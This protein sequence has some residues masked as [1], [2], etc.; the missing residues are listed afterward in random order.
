M[1]HR[2]LF[3]PIAVITITLFGFLLRLY[4]L[5]WQCL[6]VDEATTAYIASQNVSWIVHYSL[7]QDYNPPL[8]YLVA[9]Y[10]AVIFGDMS[11]FAARFPAV[12][13]GALAIPV[14]YFVGKEFD[15][16][17]LGLLLAS[18]L[19]F[20]FPFFYYS[21]NARTYSL[22]MLAFLGFVYFWLRVYKGDARNL[23][24]VWLSG[25]IALCFWSHYYSVVPIAIMMMFLLRKK[26]TV[27][28]IAALTLLFI[29][30]LIAMFDFSQFST[31]TNHGVFNV[32]WVSPYQIALT[33][34]NEMFCWS[35]VVIVPLAFYS[36]WKYFR[37]DLVKIFTAAS[38][39]PALLI[40]PMARFTAVMPR[41][42]VFV[43]PLVM[44]VAM[45]P[46]SRYI[47]D[48]KDF[49]KKIAVF[50]GVAFL[51][52]LLNYGSIW[53]WTSYDVCP[54]MEFYQFVPV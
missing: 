41:Y 37:N 54:L 36:L 35:V 13:F 22:V 19:S 38:F 34:P 44:A 24:L 9:H 1:L 23:T 4:R 18:L 42:A 40:I 43:A 52:F 32:L 48:A 16:K 25:C 29:S 17:T 28:K 46:V 10:S 12:I 7:G 3:F 47:D 5:D 49:D 50:L 6:M 20:M 30:P 27:I 53:S 26:S 21:Q 11:R 51:V 8:Y 31:R 39:I 45:L 15:S 33:T 14:A 2:R